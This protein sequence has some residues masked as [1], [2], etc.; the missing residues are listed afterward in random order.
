MTD[1]INTRSADTQAIH[2]ARRS[3]AID[4]TADVDQ[5][6]ALM[7]DVD[8]A[9][10]AIARPPVSE[11]ELQRAQTYAAALSRAQQGV[12]QALTA[13]GMAAEIE[14][15]RAAYTLAEHQLNG[16]LA[17]LPAPEQPSTLP[18]LMHSPVLGSVVAGIADSESDADFWRR[19]GDVI[20]GVKND[21]LGVYETAVEKNN[22]FQNAFTHIVTQLEQW[23]KGDDKNT[24]LK[25]EGSKKAPKS[26]AEMA[27]LIAETR[28]YNK[29]LNNSAGRWRPTDDASIRL[30]LENQGLD[31]KDVP[32]GL[33]DALKDLRDSFRDGPS[34]VFVADK[35]D[36]YWTDEDEKAGRGKSGEKITD[37]DVISQ[38]NKAIA[39]KWAIDLGLPDDAILKSANDD[40]T[41]LVK[42]DFSP[43]NTMIDSLEAMKKKTPPDADGKVTLSTSHF[44][45]WKT[46]FD[47]QADRIKNKSTVMAQKL[48]NAQSIYENLI[49]VL[50]STIAAMMETNKLFLQN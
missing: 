13:R 40:I 9:V 47:A 34:T 29:N 41:W 6:A 25:L 5:A 11:R 39:E 38:R 16:V 35:K 27:K 42:L 10:A 45:A 4:A 49:K 23:Q 1:Y 15:A 31:Q 48:V 14:C 3:V 37:P 26:E 30:Q 21:Y 12:V 43:V 7:A 2:A 22:A 8:A 28:E 17:H 32:D 44:Q 20:G 36:F 24:T 46:G 18:P 19:I 33:L 50:S